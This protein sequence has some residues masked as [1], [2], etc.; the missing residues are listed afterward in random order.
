MPILY[1]LAQ[2]GNDVPHSPVFYSYLI[3]DTTGAKLFVDNN[4]VTD[5]VI[6]HLRTAGVELRPYEAILSELER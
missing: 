3:V 6:D 4:K 5:Q 1:L 2:R